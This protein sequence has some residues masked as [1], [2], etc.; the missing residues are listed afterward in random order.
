M[1]KKL[2]SGLKTLACYAGILLVLAFAGFALKTLAYAIPADAVR[3]NIESGADLYRRFGDYPVINVYSVDKRPS[4]L[5]FFTETELLV[6][7]WK[8]DSAHPMMSAV[9]NYTFT[10]S[11]IEKLEA[12]VRDG[13]SSLTPGARDKYWWGALTLLRPLLAVCSYAEASML[14]QAAFL[15]AFVLCGLCLY[16]RFGGV[17]FAAFVLG[18]ICVDGMNAAPLFATAFSVL[19]AFGGIA[20]VCRCKNIDKSF[21]LILFITGIATAYFDWMS[22]PLIACGLPVLAG[23]VRL[24]QEKKLAGFWRGVWQTL[25]AGLAWALGWG[26]MIAAKWGIS[27]LVSG[28]SL[29][30][31]LRGAL[32]DDIAAGELT[33]PFA[34]TCVKLLGSTLPGR[35]AITGLLQGAQTQASFTDLYAFVKETV[36]TDPMSLIW[37]NLWV[38]AIALA[39]TALYVA[40]LLRCKD[41]NAFTAAILCLCVAAVPFA[42]ALVMGGHTSA[43]YW[44]VYRMLAMTF[45]GLMLSVWYALRGQLGF[46]FARRSQK[47][48]VHEK[49]A[50]R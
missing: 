12:V 50:E 30:A 42:W 22:S 35:F 17:P 7:A 28:R 36:R 27:W 45:M 33:T 8:V 11:G 48:N 3:E 4:Q 46:P 37:P 6:G 40:L 15:L 26:G 34:I 23:V 18:F 16:R 10:N 20:A 19:C 47:E 38:L 21:S 13:G 14:L 49:T 5:D 1:Q 31:F 29:A 24:A 32:I 44:F 25:R 2:I 39:L 43:H 41:K 9:E